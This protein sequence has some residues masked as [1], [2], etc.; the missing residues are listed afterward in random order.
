M[1]EVGLERDLERSL[2]GGWV[3]PGARRSA[4][5]QGA[6]WTCVELYDDGICGGI[7]CTVPQSACGALSRRPGPVPL[8]ADD[9]KSAE[10]W[11][12]YDNDKSP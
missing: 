8:S 7:G 10:L 2:D 4:S 6:M 12:R 9:R 5:Y 3:V 11:L 1:G